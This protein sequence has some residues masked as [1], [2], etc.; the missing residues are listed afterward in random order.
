MMNNKSEELLISTPYK[1]E[2]MTTATQPP[3][4]RISRRVRS[5][6][7]QMFYARSTLVT[8]IGDNHFGSLVAW[9]RCVACRYPDF[10][11]KVDVR[12]LDRVR[13]KLDLL[14]LVEDWYRLRI[15]NV[16]VKIRKRYRSQ[17]LLSVEQRALRFS[18]RKLLAKVFNL[19]EELGRQSNGDEECLLAKYFE[20]M[21]EHHVDEFSRASEFRCP[22]H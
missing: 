17:T 18:N 5:E 21:S 4:T 2:L 22:Y 11:F 6:T 19:A 13:C 12:L 1:D 8:Y 7:L 10:R 15:S 14:P 9:A 16:H 3:I 20:L